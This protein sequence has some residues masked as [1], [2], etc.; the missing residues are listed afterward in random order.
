MRIG[1]F[2]DSFLPIVDGVGRV[3]YNYCHTLGSMGH[4]VSAIVPMENMGYR[5]NFPFEIIDYY[6]ST[7]PSTVYN[8]G[9]PLFD[10][11]YDKRLEMTSFEIVHVHTPFIAGLQGVKYAKSHDIPIV[12]SFHSKYYDDFLQITGSR[13]LAKFG[14][15]II[16]NFYDKCDEV[17]TVSENSAETLKT[18]GYTKPIYVIGNGLDIKDVDNNLAIKAREHFGLDN[19]VP[20]L[21]YVG[22]INWK[23][24]LERILESCSLL[25]KSD[26]KFKLVLAGKGPHV[27]ELKQKA[28]ELD[29]FD[30]VVLTGHILDEDLLSGLYALADMFVFPSLYD[31]YSMVVR[32]AANA[33][34]ASVVV[35]GSAPAECI[36]DRE[37]GMLCD[38]TSDSLYEVL[39]ECLTNR[40]MLIRLGENAKKT[41]PVSWDVIMNQAVDRYKI[42]I[43]N[44]RNNK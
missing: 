32:E 33:K 19:N 35:R 15:D 37:N 23:K 17:W 42:V 25:K 10:N 30:D 36:K 26:I 9:I 22:Q 13:H 14:T 27:D 2:S 39:K 38:D 7:V 41:I 43:E 18:Y 29:I 20:I 3:V 21:L 31:T 8:A 40:D 24:N 1:Q 11:H 44:Y 28:K 5:G 16:V 34:T 4:E 12:G 6:S